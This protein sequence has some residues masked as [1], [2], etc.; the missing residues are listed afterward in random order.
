M[1][2]HLPPAKRLGPGDRRV[3]VGDRRVH[4]T[5]KAEE[6]A[7]CQAFARRAEGDGVAR[8]SGE[9]REFIVESSV[10]STVVELELTA[11]TRMGMARVV[12]A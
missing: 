1:A 12:A 7:G 3:R 4:Y 8:H 6:G 2:R 9:A 5:G 11:M 10:E